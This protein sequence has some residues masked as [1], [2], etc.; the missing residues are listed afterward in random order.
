MP[1]DKRSTKW[2]DFNRI[3]I[4]KLHKKS[5]CKQIYLV[6]IQVDNQAN[7]KKK[8]NVNRRNKI[9]KKSMQNKMQIQREC[10]LSMMID[11]YDS[12]CWIKIEQEEWNVSTDDVDDDDDEST[13]IKKLS[14]NGTKIRF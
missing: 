5:L 3:N 8:K 6:N 7:R 12:A 10:T 13:L 11:D 14:G 9:D 2:S 1:S 4:Y